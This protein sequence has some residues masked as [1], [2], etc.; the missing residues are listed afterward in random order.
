MGSNRGFSILPGWAEGPFMGMTDS[1][2]Q[3]QTVFTAPHPS[4]RSRGF[5]DGV[6]LTLGDIHV[7]IL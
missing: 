7:D 2:G 1:R 4:H 3:G 5:M 6:W